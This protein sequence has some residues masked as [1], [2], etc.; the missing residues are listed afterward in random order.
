M[1][2]YLIY[3]IRDYQS[4]IAPS[5]R[6]PNNRSIVREK[7]GKLVC[8]SALGLRREFNAVP[9]SKTPEQSSL[10]LTVA[11]VSSFL[12]LSPFLRIS[13]LLLLL[14]GLVWFN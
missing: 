14:A 7:S 8:P 2:T 12:L 9:E 5:V 10:E 13:L 3:A 4:S 11:A 6:N 1:I